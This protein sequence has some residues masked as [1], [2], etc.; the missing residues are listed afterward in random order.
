MTVCTPVLPPHF[1]DHRLNGEPIRYRSGFLAHQH[2]SA[3][4]GQPI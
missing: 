1:D 4:T 2:R 3:I